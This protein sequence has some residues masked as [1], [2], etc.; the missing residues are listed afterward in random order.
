MALSIQHGFLLVLV[1]LVLL[2]VYSFLEVELFV[3]D[4]HLSDVQFV[5]DD[6]EESSSPSAA[7]EKVTFSPLLYRPTS[8]P[9]ISPIIISQAF[10]S[11]SPEEGETLSPASSPRTISPSTIKPSQGLCFVFDRRLL[12]D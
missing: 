1:L 4:F 11:A 9:T 7:D 2:S 12:N 6:D 5:D 8:L 3:D 10:K